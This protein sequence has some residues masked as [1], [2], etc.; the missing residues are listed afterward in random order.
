MDKFRKSISDLKNKVFR[1]F[2]LEVP[3]SESVIQ[4]SKN[5]PNSLAS[6][7]FLCFFLPFHIDSILIENSSSSSE[8]VECMSNCSKCD[9]DNRPIS[10][11][12]TSSKCRASKSSVSNQ[13]AEDL[14]AINSIESQSSKR[15]KGNDI[16]CDNQML[17]IPKRSSNGFEGA[18]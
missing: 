12:G 5:T 3:N 15:F 11:S 10:M 6:N 18:E 4:E 14:K 2:N 1:I 17:Q 7:P 8:V 13:L 16:E 9:S